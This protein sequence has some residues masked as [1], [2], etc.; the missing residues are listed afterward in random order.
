MA[1][2]TLI[3]KI[4]VG[5]QNPANFVGRVESVD[6]DANLELLNMTKFSDD[7]VQGAPGVVR[8][9]V[10]HTNA[11]SDGMFPTDDNKIAATRG[12]LTNVFAAQIPAKVTAD[13]PVVS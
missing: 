13:E 4:D 3:Y 12:I 5:N 6:V 1:T 2:V 9:I 11:T 7:T 10:L 8:T